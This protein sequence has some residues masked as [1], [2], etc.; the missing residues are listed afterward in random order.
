VSIEIANSGMLLRESSEPGFAWFLPNAGVTV[1]AQ[2][3]TGRLQDWNLPEDYEPT[4]LDYTENSSHVFPK[5]A[6]YA[7]PPERVT[8]M[9]SG[10]S[11]ANTTPESNARKVDIVPEK[12]TMTVPPPPYLEVPL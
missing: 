3:V 2:T 11:R 9:V 12:K 1:P 8:T 6:V 4:P 10:E 7:G 5:S